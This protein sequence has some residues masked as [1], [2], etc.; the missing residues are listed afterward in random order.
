MNLKVELSD[1]RG[2]M[3]IPVK[4]RTGSVRDDGPRRG[5]DLLRGK[6]AVMRD[7]GKFRERFVGLL[8]SSGEVEEGE[9]ER[10]EGA[11]LLRATVE[12]QCH[13]VVTLQQVTKSRPVDSQPVPK[14]C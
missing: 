8:E 9:R 10:E 5:P 7:E 2:Y 6:V 1:E 14:Q 13:Y 4:E 3:L 12:V 11:L